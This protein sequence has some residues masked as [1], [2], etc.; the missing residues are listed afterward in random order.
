MSP[1][2]T[3]G[4]VFCNGVHAV[5]LLWRSYYFHNKGVPVKLWCWDNASTDGAAEYA[6]KHSA[7]LFRNPPRTSHQQG[8]DSMAKECDTPFFLLLDFDV[9][10]RGEFTERALEM[11]KFNPGAL[12]VS[13]PSGNPGKQFPVGNF[14]L[15][16]GTK[17]INPCCTLFRSD[18]IK[19]ILEH[20]TFG[21]YFNFGTKRQFF[22]VGAMIRQVAEVAGMEVL[23]PAWVG[24]AV[25]HFGQI[26]ALVANHDI[27]VNLRGELERRY[28]MMTKRAELYEEPPSTFGNP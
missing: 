23:E 8:A 26:G 25:H 24:H 16:D 2:V 3:V 10:F 9:E 17:R 21:T 15:M 6:A 5:E 27:P 7:K 18:K 22:D 4:T 19:R 20:F 14:G 11:L 1:E 13:Y 28:A 12:C